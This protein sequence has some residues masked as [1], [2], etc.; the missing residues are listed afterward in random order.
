MNTDPAVERALAYASCGWP[1]FPCQPGSKQPATR[2]GFLDATTDPDR[3]RWWWRRDPGANLAIATGTP[4][5]DV[6]DVD[7]HGAA[8]SGYAALNRL[9]RAGLIR[10]AGAV[11][12]TPHGGLHLYYAGTDQGCGK[13][14]AQH[15]DYRSRGGYVLAPP[16]QVD[17]RPYRVVRHQPQAGPF[18]WDAAVRLLDPA[19][20]PGP[21]PAIRE[22]GGDLSH[23]AGW[24]ARLTEGNRND[25]LFW[26]ACRAAE[27]GDDTTL[28]SLAEA[29]RE[30]GLGGREITATISS[31]R[32]TVTR[33]PQP[34]AQER[35]PGRQPGPADTEPGPA[36]GQAGWECAS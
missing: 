35:V 19:R 33:Q 18:E 21:R 25:G 16:S 9:A 1:V 3:I 12:A 20:Q 29:A 31:A 24:V 22:A 26:A 10:D 2:H 32:R 11:V 27:A 36:S 15:L 6:L 30:A 4:G 17:G 14:P 23:L 7:Q 28:E 34:Q 13:L 8:G 5:P